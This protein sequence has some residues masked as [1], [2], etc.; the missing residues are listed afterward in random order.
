ME[1]LP[2]VNNV[3]NKFNEISDPPDLD[4]SIVCRVLLFFGWMDTTCVINDHQP[5]QQALAGQKVL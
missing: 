5:I 3:Y 4:L 1:M 2:K